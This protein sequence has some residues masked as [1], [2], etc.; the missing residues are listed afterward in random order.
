MLFA[1]IVFLILGSSS[2]DNSASLDTMF[3]KSRFL[4]YFFGKITAQ[5]EKKKENFFRQKTAK[6]LSER[7][8]TIE[9]VRNI[10][11]ARK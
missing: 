1:V 7:Q 2:R 11:L 9:N 5:K 10:V 3:E 8:L 6:I 4:S